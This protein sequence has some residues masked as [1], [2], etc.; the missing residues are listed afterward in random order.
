MTKCLVPGCEVELSY[1]A[2]T[3]VCKKHIHEEGYC[4]CTRCVRLSVKNNIPLVPMVPV[5]K[6]DARTVPSLRQ[7]PPSVQ[8]VPTKEIPGTKI[9]T[10]P[11]HAT[12]GAAVGVVHIRM[13]AAPWD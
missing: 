10:Q 2:T 3:G 13:P 5:K 1:W 4:H 8:F 7:R 9:V 12:T 11:Y 6:P